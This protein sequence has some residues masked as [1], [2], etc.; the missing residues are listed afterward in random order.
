[1]HSPP[2]NV[3][4]ILKEIQIKNNI[5]FNPEIMNQKIDL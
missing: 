2:N 1:L 4:F 3:W 5:L